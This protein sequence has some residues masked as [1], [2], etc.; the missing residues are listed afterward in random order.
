MA[1]AQTLSPEAAAQL[2]AWYAE[3]GVD[4]ALDDEPRNRFGEAPPAPVVQA[5]PQPEPRVREAA[6]MQ[7]ASVLALPHEQVLGDARNA[8]ASASTLEELRALL[9]SYE[10]IGLRRTATQLVF[11]DGNPAA[12]VMMVGEAPG[13]EEDREGTPFVGPAGQLL[14]RMLAAIGLDRSGV[15]IANVVPWRPPG[16]RTPTVQEMELCLPFIRRQIEL[17]APDILVILGGSALSA[18]TGSKEGILKAR[19]RWTDYEAGARTIPALATLHPAYLLRTPLQ[20][21]LAWRDFRALK[22]RLEGDRSGG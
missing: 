4:I 1:D 21:R 9:E 5:P 19:G 22:A 17:A 8:A 16:N 2:L 15:Y 12:R 11:A 20:K 18:L 3:M 7:P 14:D 13:R 6:P 10:A